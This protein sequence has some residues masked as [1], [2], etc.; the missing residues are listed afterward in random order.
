MQANLEAENST[1]HQYI[2]TRCID[3][4]TNK[5]DGT[6]LARQNHGLLQSLSA[7]ALLV[8]REFASEYM[9]PPAAIRVARGRLYRHAIEVHS[10][11]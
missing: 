10:N 11:I 3:R 4:F 6:A 8:A 1:L 2:V 7:P 5:I 9:Q